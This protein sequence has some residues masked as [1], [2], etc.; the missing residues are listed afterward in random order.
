MRPWPDAAQPESL[1]AVIFAGSKERGHC[2]R[3][4]GGVGTHEC[5]DHVR[6]LLW[7]QTVSLQCHPLPTGLQ[8]DITTI[9]LWGVAS[10]MTLITQHTSNYTYV[11]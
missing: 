11:T 2:C 9:T 3:G 4:I 10:H 1:T 5:L 7:V 8:G 6:V